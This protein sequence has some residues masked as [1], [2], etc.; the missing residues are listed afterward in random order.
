M[1]KEVGFV[2]F[3]EVNT[4]IERLQAKHD[5][6]LEALEAMGY[7]LCDGGLVIDDPEYR[8][9]DAAIA[10]L[11]NFPMSSLIVCIA[12]W[13]PTHAVLRVTDV[14]RTVPMVLWGLCGWM[15]N[16][17]LVTTAEQAG[18]TALRGGVGM[19]AGGNKPIL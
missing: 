4:P 8:T 11:R 7:C 12:G 19:P 6:A 3:G 1:K 10:R 14:F 17:R 13:I 5:Q 15:E 2:C 9:A 16:G 18:T